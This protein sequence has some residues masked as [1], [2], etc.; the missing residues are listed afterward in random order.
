V[1]S[2]APGGL[3]R[4]AAASL[5]VIGLTSLGLSA[6]SF[7]TDPNFRDLAFD[8]VAARSLLHGHN[9]YAPM[10]TMTAR[11]L[12]GYKHSRIGFVGQ[13]PLPLPY[14]HTPLRLLLHVPLAPLPF[15]A[16]GVIWT[17]ISGTC[18]VSAIVLFARMLRWR[19][20]VVW[21][22]AIGLSATP[23]VRQELHFGQIEGVLLLLVVLT[24]RNLTKGHDVR[25]GI[26]LSLAIALKLF[27]GFLVLPL[28][29]QRRFRATFTAIGLSVV[30]FMGAWIATGAHHEVFALMARAPE[31]RLFSVSL[32]GLITR[33]FPAPETLIYVTFGICAA[34]AIRPPRRTTRDV[35][36][37]AAPLMLLGLPV[38]WGIYY[39]V[40]LPWLFLLLTRA[41]GMTRALFAI[42]S[43]PILLHLDILMPVALLMAV[44]IEAA[45][46]NAKGPPRRV[47][48]CVSTD[49][50][51]A[52]RSEFPGLLAPRDDIAGET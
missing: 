36:W 49:E 35:Y 46:V 3:R 52:Q 5:I 42:L 27:P 6:A 10:E 19:E 9:P 48:P 11:E 37:A 32:A 44:V 45:P 13:K 40:G 2:M 12:P 4:I 20:P 23:L 39:V 51:L 47:A 33:F 1:H 50:Q 25:A 38:T 28:F 14:W 41:R 43:L 26:W 21:A 15:P 22:I 31:F 30:L 7:T 18:I 24:W 16:A 17:L 29:G 34:L 8:H